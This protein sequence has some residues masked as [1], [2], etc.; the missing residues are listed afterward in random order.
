MIERLSSICEYQLALFY[1][2]LSGFT[3]DPKVIEAEVRSNIQ[4]HAVFAGPHSFCMIWLPKSDALEKIP[5]VLHLHSEGGRQETRAL[6]DA[7]LNFVR[8]KGYNTLRA[9]N[10]SGRRDDVWARTF[11]HK[12]WTQKPVKTVFDFEVKK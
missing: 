4:E 3:S 9:V 2:G 5:Q 12:D 10:G 8:D 6:V 11:R 1:R 7:V